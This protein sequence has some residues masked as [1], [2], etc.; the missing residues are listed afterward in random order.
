MLGSLRTACTVIATAVAALAIASAAQA[1]TFTPVSTAV[2]ATA[3][4]ASIVYSGGTPFTCPTA[5]STGT[6]D[7]K[8]SSS[9][10]LNLTLA[11]SAVKTC[12]LDILGFSMTPTCTGNYTLHAG[13]STSITVTLDSGF[14]CTFLVTGYCSVTVVGPQTTTGTSTLNEVTTVMTLT[15]T[16][17]ATR[18]GSPNCGPA[19]STVAFS[20]SFNMTPAS[21]AIT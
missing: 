16:A 10:S 3:T 9:L 2:T 7:S 6:T 19:S 15:F 14:S 12:Q 20:M 4:N 17:A 11:K 8:S 1:Q 21:L 18:S 13:A 5:V